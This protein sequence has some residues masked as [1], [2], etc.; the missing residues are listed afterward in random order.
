MIST[1]INLAGAVLF[2]GLAIVLPR[3][4]QA[5][6]KEVELERIVITSRRAPLGLSRVSENVEV[7]TGEELNLLPARDLSEAL[8]YLPGIYIDPRRGFGRATSISIQGSASRQV[9]VMIDGI[10][11]N[12]QASGQVNP[13]KFPIEDI[14]RIEV[15]KGPASSAWGS[16]LGG[17]INVITKDTGN[18]LVPKGKVTS[19]YAGFSTKKES[20]DL[21]G[22]AAGLGYYLFSSYMDSG[23]KGPRDDVLEKKAFGKLSYDLREKGKIAGSF[24]FSQGDANSGEFPDGTWSAAPYRVQ[25]GKFGWNK[26]FQ[27]AD[28]NVDF[29]NSRQDIITKNFSSVATDVPLTD[30][31]PDVVRSRDVLYEISAV[32]SAH[33]RGKDLLTVGFDSDYDVLKTTYLEEAKSLYLQAPFANYTLKLGP[34]DLNS[35]LRFDDNSEFGSAFSPSA[36]FVYHFEEFKDTLVRFNFSRA[37]NAPPLLWK[38]YAGVSPGVTGDNP[39]IKPERARVYEL[40]AESRALS[41]LWLK[42]SLYR[43]DVKDAI[44]GAANAQGEWIQKNFQKFRRQGVEARAGYELFESL[45]LFASAAFNDIEDRATRQTVQ[46]AGS[47]RQ[48]FDLGLDYKGKTGFTFYLNGR[49]DYWNNTYEI[50]Q[51]KDRKFIFD[52][53]ASQ[54]VKALTFFLNI[55]N[56]F[57]SRYWSDYFFPAPKRYFEGGAAIEW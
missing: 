54:K 47:P 22:K 3:N 37:F 23:G 45:D 56:L 26:K 5:Q 15:V 29:K 25:Y 32:A 14:S 12:T 11:L 8:N 46:D 38:Y 10:P 17:V 57:D 35:G 9:R 55:Y 36:G 27:G 39:Q 28:L 34:W 51:P 1:R 19:S 42:L 40:G 6:E 16:S 4:A 24:G 53:K 2:T 21:S 44:S 20:F 48:S 49:Y 52:L 13:A 7:I 41:P 31:P 50:F 30:A 43:Q 33:P 18:K